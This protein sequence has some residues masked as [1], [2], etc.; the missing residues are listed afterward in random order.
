MPVLIA[1]TRRCAW[2]ACLLEEE[3]SSFAQRPCELRH[4]ILRS[5][6]ANALFHINFFLAMRHLCRRSFLIS[7][8][9]Q[10]GFAKSSDIVRNIRCAWI[11]V[12]FNKINSTFVFFLTPQY[13]CCGMTFKSKY[14]LYPKS[15]YF[16]QYISEEN[17]CVHRTSV[18]AYY[19]RVLFWHLFYWHLLYC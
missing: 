15:L 6:F 10:I 19:W 1:G 5:F 16:E 7:V 12:L 13:N 18:Y 9:L 14:N 11:L 3:W 8:K 2:K 17:I 4:Y